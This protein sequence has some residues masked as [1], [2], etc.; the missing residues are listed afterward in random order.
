MKRE[1][2]QSAVCQG[3]IKI[4]CSE[5]GERGLKQKKDG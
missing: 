1:A 5:N 4:S 2:N 3:A